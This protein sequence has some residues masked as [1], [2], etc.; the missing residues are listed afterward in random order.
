MMD[1]ARKSIIIISIVY[2]LSFYFLVRQAAYYESIYEEISDIFS[3]K[4]IP[5]GML[6]LCPQVYLQMILVAFLH[7]LRNKHDIVKQLMWIWTAIFVL[8]SA[9]TTL[10]IYAI[11]NG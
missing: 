1:V 5:S 3:Y 6:M 2:F 4:G 11:N 8:G 10:L 9:W 7:F